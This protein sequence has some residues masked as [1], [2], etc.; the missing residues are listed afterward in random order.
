[1]Y[2][3]FSNNLAPTLHA[4]TRTTCTFCSISFSPK[5]SNL[6]KGGNFQS[7]LL[8][9]AGLLCKKGAQK[10]TLRC[11]LHRFMWCKLFFENYFDVRIT[12]RK[13]MLPYF[14]HILEIIKDLPER[15]FKNTLAMPEQPGDWPPLLY[16]STYVLLKQIRTN[17]LTLCKICLLCVPKS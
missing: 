13:K 1:M 2:G 5:W 9:F 4:G 17:L 12:L 14:R 15:S 10:W 6:V 8:P 7:D 16:K 3:T 11:F